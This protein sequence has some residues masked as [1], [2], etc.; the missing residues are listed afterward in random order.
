MRLF[1]AITLD[2]PVRRALIAAQDELRQTGADARWVEPAN[3]HLTLRFLGDVPESLV[4]KLNE[5]LANACAPMLTSGAPRIPVG[6]RDAG[7]RAFSMDIVGLGAFPNASRPRVVWAGCRELTPTLPGLYRDIE[8]GILGLGLP[9]DDLS[10]SAGQAGNPFMAHI[11]LGRVKSSKGVDKLATVINSNNSK[12]FGS[13]A[14]SG[15]TL[16][17]SKLTPS[18]PIY[19]EVAR[20]KLG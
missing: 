17:E 3:I 13:Q 12:S 14:V 1:V 5:A 2:E 15:V 10:S 18:G 20:Y 19:K 6:H 4:P 7:H 8:S 9:G 16:F 11:T